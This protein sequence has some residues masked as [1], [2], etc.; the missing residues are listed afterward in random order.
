MGQVPIVWYNEEGHIGYNRE[1]SRLAKRD[2]SQL[3]NSVKDKDKWRTI[4]DEYND[5]QITLSKE[6]IELIKRIRQGRFPH[7]EVRY[8]LHMHNCKLCNQH[9]KQVELTFSRSVRYCDID[10]G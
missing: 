7:V 9:T 2:K 1:G 6:E 4:Y 5:E 8:F 10:G 3:E